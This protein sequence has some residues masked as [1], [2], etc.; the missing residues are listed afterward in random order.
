MGRKKAAGEALVL[1]L[2]LFQ[3]EQAITETFT[4]KDCKGKTNG[5]KKKSHPSPDRIAAPE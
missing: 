1:Y 5:G 2:V 4:A 3:F